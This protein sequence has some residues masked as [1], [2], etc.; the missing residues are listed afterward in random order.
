MLLQDNHG[1][2]VRDFETA[3]AAGIGADQEIVHPHQVIPGLG[4][5]GPVE[6]AGPGREVLLFGAPQPTD[7]EFGLL[8]ALRAGENAFFTLRG[9]G[10]KISLVHNF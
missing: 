6:V 2:I 4:E 5:F 10:V 3:A 9:F 8:P 1:L 7:R